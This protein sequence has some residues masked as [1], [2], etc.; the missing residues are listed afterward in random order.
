M[1]GAGS[2]ATLGAHR[3]GSRAPRQRRGPRTAGAR[4]DCRLTEAGCRRAPGRR[5]RAP[6]TNPRRRH[7]RG[8]E[9]LLREAE[10]VRLRS[11]VAAHLSAAERL[12]AEDYELITP[13]GAV[14]SSGPTS[15]GSPRAT[16]TTRSSRPSPTSG[17]AC[18]ARLRS[19]AT[20]FG[21]RSTSAAPMTR[22]ASGI[23]MP[24]SS[25]MGSGRRSG[26]RPHASA[27]RTDVGALSFRCDGASPSE[28][29]AS[30]AHRHHHARD[31]GVHGREVRSRS[32]I[33]QRVASGT[34]QAC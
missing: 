18:T 30:S 22:A 4:T 3:S 16:S 28:A 32:R 2:T 13:G 27:S 5:H 12:H 20:A 24:T 21:S 1:A 15:T 8:T 7:A 10:R 9:A 33:G 29:R 17:C 34:C 14:M 19:S 11:L 23:P 6:R 31:P 26:R 25:A